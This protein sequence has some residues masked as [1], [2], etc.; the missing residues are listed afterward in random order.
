MP[1]KIKS[2]LFLLVF[3]LAALF[4]YQMEQQDEN[5]ENAKNS[6]M[7]SIEMTKMDTSDDID[8][9]KDIHSEKD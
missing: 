8:T 2:S 4:C 9:P 7:V 1:P 3:I 5:E 6:D